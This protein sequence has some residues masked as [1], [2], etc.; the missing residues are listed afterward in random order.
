MR[1]E[2]TAP[3]VYADYIKALV[4]A[5]AARKSS[6]EQRGAGVATTSG[7]LATLLFA[8]V[9]VITAA[10]NFSLPTSAHGYLAAAIIL[11]AAAVAIG[12]IANLPFLYEEAE[13]TPDQL[14]EVW[15]YTEPE[16]QGY[17]IATRLTVLS[18][19][20]RANALKARLVLFAG[21]AQLAALVML[22]VAVLTIVG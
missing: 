1:D 20:R 15:D 13:P 17:I 19:A 3:D 4:D 14:A 22:V 2:M 12:I 5:E 6:L 21:A 7:T 9:G 18:S 10:K 16:A 11:F 8:L